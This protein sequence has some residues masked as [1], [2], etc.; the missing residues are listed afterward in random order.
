MDDRKNP[1]SDAAR[2]KPLFLLTLFCV[3]IFPHRLNASAGSSC[4]PAPLLGHASDEGLSKYLMIDR[5][6]SR[7]VEHALLDQLTI[8]TQFPCGMDITVMG[9]ISL[10]G[11]LNPER[12]G[13]RNQRLELNVVRSRSCCA[14]PWRLSQNYVVLDRG[15]YG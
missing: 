11:L 10:V 1:T 12:D 8:R 5:Q 7:L 4:M 3:M 2:A 13:L 15:F 14:H 9:K 6:L